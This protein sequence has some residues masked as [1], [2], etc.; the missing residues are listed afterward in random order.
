MPK[1]TS[2]ILTEEKIR[3]FDNIFQIYKKN[4]KKFK[5]KNKIFAKKMSIFLLPAE[6]RLDYST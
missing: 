6:S 2:I 4:K 3:D 1:G 5:K